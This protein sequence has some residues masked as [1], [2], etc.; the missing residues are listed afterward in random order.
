MCDM[1]FVKSL[2]HNKQLILLN[3]IIHPYTNLIG[4]KLIIHSS[5]RKGKLANYPVQFLV[6]S[7][8]KKDIYQE[9]EMKTYAW[10]ICW[11]M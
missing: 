1:A 8:K 3:V 4:R 6:V 9:I 2:H 5:Q 7:V 10:N 11:C